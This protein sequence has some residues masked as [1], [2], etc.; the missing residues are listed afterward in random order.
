MKQP[1][2]NRTRDA[3]YDA[4]KKHEEQQKAI[5]TALSVHDKRALRIGCKGCGLNLLEADGAVRDEHGHWCLTCAGDPAPKPTRTK[6][7]RSEY[8]GYPRKSPGDPEPARR[9]GAERQAAY[10]ARKGKQINVILPPDV[11]EA[12]SAYME[13]QAKDGAAMTQS[14]VIAKLLRQQ[15][16]RKR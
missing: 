4:M 11:A 8:S 2:D 13:R 10:R 3:F 7:E 14:E 15:L 9:T 6:V 5:P 16:L 1:E 12:F